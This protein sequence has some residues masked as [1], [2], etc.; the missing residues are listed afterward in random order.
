ML[1][2][3][4]KLSETEFSNKFA[5][6]LQNSVKGLSIVSIS[7]LDIV[8]TFTDS[9][10]RRHFLDNAYIEYSRDTKALKQVL[11][12]YLRASVELYMPDEPINKDR[13]IP[14][15][16]DRRF[17]G[18]L[19]ELSANAKTQQVYEAYNSELYIFYVEDTEHSIRYLTKADISD[20]ALSMEELRELAIR[21]LDQLEVKMHGENGYYM[22][23]A[24]GTYEASLILLDIW[25][26][27]T[28]AVNGDIVIGIPSRDLLIITG[29]RDS[30]NLHRMYDIIEEVTG[31]G[32]YLVSDKLFEL[33]G[34]KF[35][36]LN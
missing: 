34:D 30:E 24:G 9:E 22:L 32:N 33:K 20:L 17:I 26:N 13:V 21:N 27:S 15:I 4:K 14:V 11:D 18:G 5:K 19:A 7:G 2:R 29:S 8:T 1:F 36:V 12:K 25:Y 10:E 3:R 31:T 28:F 16:K 35:E 23:T 6:A